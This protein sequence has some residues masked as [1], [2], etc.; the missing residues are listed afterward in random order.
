MHTL[1]V[2]DE[3]CGQE[4]V[5]GVDC[6]RVDGRMHGLSRVET[7]DSGAETEVCLILEGGEQ[8]NRINDTMEKDSQM[9]ADLQITA[10]VKSSNKRKKVQMQKARAVLTP[11]SYNLG[12]Y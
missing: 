10:A 6:E 4:P 1:K 5:S 7:S 11:G 9:E 12:E 8:E 3:S 2:Y